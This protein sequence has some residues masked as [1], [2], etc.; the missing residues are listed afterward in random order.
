MGIDKRTQRLLEIIG[1]KY[2]R[3]CEVDLLLGDA[4]KAETKL[5]WKREYDLDKLIVDMFTALKNLG[6]NIT[7]IF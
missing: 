3:P 2:F 1:E 4:S 5:G 7:K 6:T